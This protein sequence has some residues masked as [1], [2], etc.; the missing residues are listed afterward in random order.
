MPSPVGTLATSVD[1]VLTVEDMEG[2]EIY[3]SH[4]TAPWELHVPSDPCG[5]IAIWTRP[6]HGTPLNWKRLGIGALV[7]GIMFFVLR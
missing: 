7:A 5:V 6:L 1:D 2:V 4:L 3:T